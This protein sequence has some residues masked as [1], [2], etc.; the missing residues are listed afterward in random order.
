MDYIQDV[1]LVVQIRDKY[2]HY[3]R[4]VPCDELD[5]QIVVEITGLHAGFPTVFVCLSHFSQLVQVEDIPNV[6]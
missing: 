5:P 6:P 4:D 2:N 3:S 1:I